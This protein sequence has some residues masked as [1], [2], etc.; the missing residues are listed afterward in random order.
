MLTR[1]MQQFHFILSSVLS[2]FDDLLISSFL[3]FDHS[4]LFLY[5]HL[6]CFLYKF[7]DSLILRF[8]SLIMLLL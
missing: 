2:S 7:H 5:L 8:Y 1:H 4:N 3:H 6:L